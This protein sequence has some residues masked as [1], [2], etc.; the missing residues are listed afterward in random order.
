MV[1]RQLPSALEKLLEQDCSRNTFRD[2]AVNLPHFIPEVQSVTIF[3]D[4]GF[5]KEEIYYRVD[6][7]GEETRYSFM[8]GYIP[9][10]V[11]RKNPQYKDRDEDAI[12]FLQPLRY[13]DSQVKPLSQPQIIQLG[14][15]W[16]KAGGA[17]V[18]EVAFD[19]R[20]GLLALEYFDLSGYTVWGMVDIVKE[21]ISYMPSIAKKCHEI[22]GPVRKAR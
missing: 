18:F 3:E 11:L 19:E 7:R 10:E 17:S 2:L 5:P 4:H 1:D 12:H 22:F 21:L 14:N 16:E 8:M 9:V 13:S 20:E 6:V 15:W